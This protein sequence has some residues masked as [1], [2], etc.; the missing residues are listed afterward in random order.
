MRSDEREHWALDKRVNIAHV[1]TTIS[2]AAAMTGF[3][4]RQEARMVVLEEHRMNQIARD[5]RQDVD[6]RDLRA[7]VAVAMRELRDEI[8][9]LR[10]DLG[11]ANR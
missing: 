8:R 2:L 1:I 3:L 11:K 6:L 5:L 9:A 4:M 10:S 7:D